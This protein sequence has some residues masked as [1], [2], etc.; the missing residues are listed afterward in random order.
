MALLGKYV[1]TPFE[2]KERLIDYSDWLQAAELL[3]VVTFA[4]TP[5][6]NSPVVCTSSIN[7][8][9]TAVDLFLSGGDDGSQYKV[10]VTATTNRGEI[11]QDEIVLL[12]KAL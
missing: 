8:G 2:K 3:T 4:V 12:V 5:V 6:G 7:S 11:K 9:N 1:Q 10:I